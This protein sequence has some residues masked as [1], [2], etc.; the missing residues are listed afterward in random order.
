MALKMNAATL[1]R[2]EKMIEESGYVLRYERGTFQSG[3]CI[4]EQKKVVV[5]NKFLQTEGRINT[6]IDILPVLTIDPAML[7]AENRKLYD[8]LTAYIASLDT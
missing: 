2:V 5:L 8:E 1:T 7:H 6:L 3:Y 4:L